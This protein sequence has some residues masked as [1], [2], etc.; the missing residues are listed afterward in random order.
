[1][2]MPIEIELKARVEDHRALKDRLS[3]LAPAALSFD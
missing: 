1:M 3:L 2:R